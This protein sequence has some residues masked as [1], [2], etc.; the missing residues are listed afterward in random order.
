MNLRTF[1]HRV[2]N[3]QHRKD[4]KEPPP[5]SS[6]RPPSADEICQAVPGLSMLGFDAM[7]KLAD[8]NIWIGGCVP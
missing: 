2:L 4:T 7:D 6:D 1:I 5:P 8:E 3:A